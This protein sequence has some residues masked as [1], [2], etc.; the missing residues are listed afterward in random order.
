MLEAEVI[1]RVQAW[2][3]KEKMEYI[4]LVLNPRVAAG[5]PDFMYLIP[6]GRPVF[7]EYKA[8]GK[9]PTPMQRKRIK[10]LDALGYDVVV[11]DCP[12]FAI[13]YLSNARKRASCGS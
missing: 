2:A 8:T 5:W 3:K 10:D 7:I 12:D 4:R 11:A 9:K 6:G 13:G 1:K